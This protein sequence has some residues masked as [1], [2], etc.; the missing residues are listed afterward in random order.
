[1][2]VGKLKVLQGVAALIAS[3][4]ADN[5]GLGEELSRWLTSSNSVSVSQGIAVHRAVIAA[6]AQDQGNSTLISSTL[7]Y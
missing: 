6:L 5:P 3:L 4:I 1:M 2:D 7:L